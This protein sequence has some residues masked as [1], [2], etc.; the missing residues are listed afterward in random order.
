[1]AYTT[2]ENIRY[3]LDASGQSGFGTDV[4]GTYA[5]AKHITWSD[6]IIDMKLSKRYD[7]PFTTTPPA[8]ESI[9]TVLSSWKTLRSL[10]SQEIPSAQAFVKDDYDYS[11]QLLEDISA[12]KVD[13]PTGTSGSVT[14]E[15]GSST[16][17][18]SSNMN[19]TPIF[20]VDDELNQMVDTDRLSDIAG[21]RE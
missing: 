4:I 20:D 18:W 16:R 5:I 10:Y 1:M 9:S 21:A 8:I 11:M 7:V 17:V 14:A 15:K 13:I 12:S 2:D 19:Y 6:S 3:Y